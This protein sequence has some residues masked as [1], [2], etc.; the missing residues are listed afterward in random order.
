MKQSEIQNRLIKIINE[1]IIREKNEITETEVNKKL[2]GSDIGLNPRDLL[3][4][5]HEVEEEFEI[6][7]KEDTINRIGFKTIIDICRAVE[8]EQLSND[9]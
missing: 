8:K 7:F 2:M 5:F 9:C 6:K 4:L 3:V 1:K